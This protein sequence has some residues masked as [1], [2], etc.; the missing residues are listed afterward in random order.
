MTSLLTVTSNLG[1]NHPNSLPEPQFALIFHKTQ[2]NGYINSQFSYEIT[3]HEINELRGG[4][5]L[6]PGR[7]F[8]L[9]D[10]DTLITI[11]NNSE[12]EGERLILPE[13][14]LLQGANELAW[15]L[16]G[17]IRPMW[18]NLGERQTKLNVPWPA[19]LFHVQGG[20]LR[21]VALGKQGRPQVSDP[22]YQAPLM[23]IDEHGVVCTGGAVLPKGCMVEHMKA[24]EGVMFNT[25]FTHTNMDH[26]LRIKDNKEVDDKTH[27]KFWRKLAREKTKQF[28]KRNLVSIGLN[29]G[30]YLAS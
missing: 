17:A 16:P 21:V 10:L 27:L 22:V 25:F 29:V 13:N 20:A 18:F 11:L 4:Y 30:K 2:T 12:S 5:Y 15:Y 28:P 7:A 1:D 8:N 19:L 3:Q 24:W 23:N 6:G 9:S 26:T 14:L